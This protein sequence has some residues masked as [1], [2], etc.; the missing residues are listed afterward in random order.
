MYETIDGFLD[1]LATATLISKVRELCI[2]LAMVAIAVPVVL[3]LSYSWPLSW[4]SAMLLAGPVYTGAILLL[5][6]AAL[7]RVEEQRRYVE[8][9]QSDFVLQD[10]LERARGRSYALTPHRLQILAKQGA[11]DDVVSDLRTLAQSLPP[12][13]DGRDFVPEVAA[14][15][16]QARFR[17]EIES[18][19]NIHDA[20]QRLPV[21]IN[22]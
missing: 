19:M 21:T 14:V 22:E 1:Q 7:L 6:Q 20:S 16:G 3:Y 4:T 8:W 9:L 17:D 2:S 10:F 12:L 5:L 18:I 13:I 15:L 11:S